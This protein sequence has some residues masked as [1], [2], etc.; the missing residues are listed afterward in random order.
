M[1]YSPEEYEALKA[2]YKKELLERK[3]WQEKMRLTALRRRAEWHLQQ[4]KRSLAKLGLEESHS[5]LA[6]ANRPLHDSH[7]PGPEPTPK[8][9]PSEAPTPEE[10]PDKTLF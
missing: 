9:S 1:P 10:K 5:P 4:V 3:A 6:A 2:A 7:L 8:A